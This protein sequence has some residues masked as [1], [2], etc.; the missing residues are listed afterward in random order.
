MNLEAVASSG[1]RYPLVPIP[2]RAVLCWQPLPGTMVETNIPKTFQKRV[3]KRPASQMQ[4]PKQEDDADE[5]EPAGEEGEEGADVPGEEEEEEDGEANDEEEEEERDDEEDAQD[6][7]AKEKEEGKD[8]KAKMRD[9]TEKKKPSM[10][11]H[12]D[13]KVEGANLHNAVTSKHIR[14][15]I[16]AKIAGRK[17]QVVQI[18]PHESRKYQTLTIKI[19]HE[20][21]A[22]IRQG[23]SFDALR[24]CAAK[25]KMELLA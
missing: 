13:G 3:L 6:K 18:S 2:G 23:I 9:T 10:M 11:T 19:H 14:S 20:V 15:Y 22:K 5:D 7:E 24:S 16:V 8:V 25:R 21:L 17:H 12:G 4:P 1:K